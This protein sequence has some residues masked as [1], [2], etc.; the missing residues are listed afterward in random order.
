M[1]LNDY[2]MHVQQKNYPLDYSEDQFL[3]VERDSGHPH[4]T[5]EWKNS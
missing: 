4:A 2:Y 1:D 5:L 3:P